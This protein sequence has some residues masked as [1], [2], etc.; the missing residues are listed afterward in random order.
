N[1]ALATTLPAV[2]RLQGLLKRMRDLL[3]TPYSFTV[4][5][6]KA[7]NFGILVNYR[8]SWVPEQY[9]VGDLVSTIPLAPRETRRYTTKQVT[10]RSRALKEIADNLSTVRSD[11]DTTGRADRDI[12]NR[13]EN[14]TNFKVT[15]DGTFGI[16]ADKIHATAEGG[17][18][19]AK[20]SQ[21]TKKDFHEAVLKSAH[22]YKQ[23]NRTEVDTSSSDE[24]ETTTYNEI[25]NPNDELTV[26]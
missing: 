19:S 12:V 8:Q 24:S 10:K 7:C 25:Q 2:N 17:G 21:T 9:Q 22:E 15:A 13:A 18:D 16:D 20:I 14:R 26:T 11:I 6:E 5:Q 4:Y 23:D 1:T 3:S